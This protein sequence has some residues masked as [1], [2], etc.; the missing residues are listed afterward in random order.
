MLKNLKELFSLVS[1]ENRRTFIVLQL[2]VAVMAVMDVAT[3]MLIGFFLSLAGDI[4][5]IY[6]IPKYIIETS[7]IANKTELEILHSIGTLA[8]ILLILSCCISVFTTW[9]LSIFGAIVGAEISNRLFKHYLTQNWLF[10]VENSSSRL[11]NK[12]IQEAGRVSGNIISPLMQMNAKIISGIFICLALIIYDPIVTIIGALIFGGVYYSLYLTIRRYLIRNGVV[13]TRSQEAKYKIM[14]N[15]FGGIKDILILRRHD[16]FNL[17]FIKENILLAHALG[18]NQIMSQVPRFAVEFVALGSLILFILTVV[19]FNQSSVTSMLPTISVY[20][21]AMF[22]LM[23]AFQIAYTGISQIKGNLNAFEQIKEDLYSSEHIEPVA[24]SS[25][26]RI[27]LRRELRLT[28]V[29]F[30]YPRRNRSILNDVNLVIPALKTVGFVG[31]SGSGKSTTADLI[32]GLLFPT[33]GTVE[34]DGEILTQSRLGAWHQSV[35]VVSQSIFLAETSIKENIGFG[36]DSKNINASRLLSA[37][38]SSRVNEFLPG[39]PDGIDTMVGE[40]GV[41]LSGGQRQRIGVARALYGNADLLILD[42]ATSALD[43]MTEKFIMDSIQNLAGQKTIVMIA[44]RLSTVKKCDIIFLFDQGN[45]VDQGTYHEL[46]NSNKKF[47]DMA[48]LN[49]K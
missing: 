39:L 15:S 4:S 10:H 40:R 20:G 22:K 29:S 32:S 49:I 34:V 37:V 3:I 43:G 19:N 8:F 9:R 31:V 11:T 12:I 24:V 33:R 45:V 27:R 48:L 35:G 16:H 30:T 44:H 18:K 28:G 6:K 47:R 25:V 7:L 17:K 23:P 42:E 5:L 26:D 36:I 46:Y 1:Y 41:R 2:F 14:S 13:I 38:N 21:L